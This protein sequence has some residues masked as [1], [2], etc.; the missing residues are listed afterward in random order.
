MD[1]EFHRRASWLAFVVVVA[2]AW[3][4]HVKAIPIDPPAVS[5]PIEVRPTDLDSKGHVN[6]ARYLEYFQ[7]GRWKYLDGRGLSTAD[8]AALGVVAVVRN[9]NVDYL[10]E[11]DYGDRLSVATS[12]ERLGNT[13]FALRQEV[14]KSDGT[15]AARAS[16]TL[17]TIDPAARK[18]IA[19]PAAA[20]AALTK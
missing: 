1:I 8:L 13:S 11:C 16:V 7:A 15:V 2:F 4:V 14:F 18:P 5:V 12:L 6:N 3:A 19:V 20:R 17:V 9:V 10:A